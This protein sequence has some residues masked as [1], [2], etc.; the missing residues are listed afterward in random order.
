MAVVFNLSFN[1]TKHKLVLSLLNYVPYVPRASRALMPHVPRILHAAVSHVSR[2]LRTL[3]PHVLRVL[4]TLV[5][6]VSHVLR[7]LVPLVPRARRALCSKCC[8]TSVL[9]CLTCPSCLV[10]CVFHVPISPFLLLF[11]YASRDFF[12]FIFLLMH[13]F[14]K[15]ATV[16]I[17]IICW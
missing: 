4:R 15:F 1:A 13:F 3:V 5:S 14:W 10:P 12:L 9:S 8:R 6:H 17:T 7:A 16:K 11:S 2:S